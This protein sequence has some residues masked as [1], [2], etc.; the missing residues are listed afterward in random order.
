MT[1]ID[2]LR[3]IEFENKMGREGMDNI[4]EFVA[5]LDT[6]RIR[7]VSKLK[8]VFDRV[9]G[10][11]DG[12]ISFFEFRGALDRLG[13]QEP[14][15]NDG[16]IVD[17]LNKA[18]EVGKCF[19]FPEFASTYTSL[20]ANYDPDV[21]C[22][23]GQ[24]AASAREA[25]A[26]AVIKSNDAIK[27][28]GRHV[29]VRQS[30]NEH[31]RA[32]LGQSKLERMVMGEKGQSRFEAAVTQHTKLEDALFGGTSRLAEAAAVGNALDMDVGES[33]EGGGEEKEQEGGGG[34][35]NA[36]QVS[37]VSEALRSVETLAQ[38]KE[39]FDRFAVDGLLTAAE[40]IQAMTELGTSMS[41]SALATYLKSRRMY[42]PARR[43][44]FFE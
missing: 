44:N 24:A 16:K 21:R 40:L 30:G 11:D 19:D 6:D 7:L 32:S 25:A 36:R 18:E 1:A 39:M 43:I 29:S 22:G 5:A 42:T 17:W 8:V 23:D 15:L 27:F 37:I 28:A 41:R 9:D 3:E 13:L 2:E 12:E 10:D 38:V 4:S 14:M 31:L 33:K 34:V 26:N 35:N 20:F